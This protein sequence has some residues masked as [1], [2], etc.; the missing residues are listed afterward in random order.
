[1]SAPAPDALREPGAAEDFEVRELTREDVA[2]WYHVYCNRS[3]PST[4]ADTFA[5]GWGD[6]RFAPLLDES[7]APVLTYYAASTAEAAYLESVLHD[8]SLSPPGMFEVA[9]LTHYSLVRLRLPASLHY[10]SFHTPYLPRLGITRA[11]LIDSQ[12]ASYV[13]T[14]RWAQAAYL[15][16]STAQAVGYGSRR[17]DSARCLVLFRQR[18]PDPPFE[19]LGEEPLAVAPRRAEVLALVRS[20]ELHEV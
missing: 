7:G 18:L 16:R 13:H 2:V 5:E 3:H 12:P 10:V 1:V 6:T 11:Q 15:Q 14:R 4:R 20:L 9:T 19:V 8:V 17:D